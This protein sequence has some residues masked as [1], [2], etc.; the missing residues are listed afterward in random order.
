MEEVNLWFPNAE[1]GSNGNAVAWTDELNGRYFNTHTKM[2]TE[3]G[4]LV[5]SV[6]NLLC[7]SYEAAVP[8]CSLSPTTREP[9]SQVS[10]KPDIETL[11]TVQAIRTYPDI[12]SES[13]CISKLV[14]LMKHKA[15]IV[16][17]L[18]L[19]EPTAEI[20]N[21]CIQHLAPSTSVTVGSS[22]G[23]PSEAVKS[24]D[25]QITT[26]NISSSP[27]EWSDCGI[28]DQDL[29][30]ITGRIRE[31]S[32]TKSLIQGLKHFVN[33]GGK[34]IFSMKHSAFAEWFSSLGY[35]APQLRFDLPDATIMLLD[36]A[37]Y[38]N[39][40]MR[41]TENVT[42]FAPIQPPTSLMLFINNLGSEDSHVKVKDLTQFEAAE[43]NRII[44]YDI[45][46]TMLSHLQANNFEIVKGVLCSGKPIIWMTAGVNEGKSIFGGMVQGFLRALRSE[47][48]T[49]KILLMDM[50][51][52]ES[53]EYAACFVRRKLGEITTKD[54][55]HDTEFYL[56]EGVSQI[57]RIVPNDLLNEQFAPVQKPAEQAI[58]PADGHCRL[59]SLTKN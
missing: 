23:E 8:Q 11:T 37:P 9:Y 16:N 53:M 2:F 7:V 51:T 44:L 22:S 10:W 49:A 50:D 17:V 38:Q 6:K 56:R 41:T 39:G 55:G 59:S 54:S 25:R 14:E 30:I 4:Q 48:A 12:Q 18:F 35:A 31:R 34:V 33:K 15:P 43:D 29:V 5:L 42:I 57:C 28:K 40:V 20:L 13:E 58:L 47:Q 21:K 36:L 52:N 27:A 1:A 3:S 26:T 46:G 32:S 45:E 19:E 24:A